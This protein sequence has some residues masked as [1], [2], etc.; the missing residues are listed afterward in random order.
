MICESNY[1][2][3][4][5][6]IRIQIFECSHTPTSNASCAPQENHGTIA[7]S[8]EWKELCG[9]LNSVML[10]AKVVHYFV[11]SDGSSAW[12]ACFLLTIVQTLP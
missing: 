10:A 9:L 1:L 6:S 3:R 2:Q 8:M 11:P 4:Y 5:Y 7:A 12:C